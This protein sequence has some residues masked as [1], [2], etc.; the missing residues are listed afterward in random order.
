M[1]KIN[2]IAQKKKGKLPIILGVDLAQINFKAIAIIWALCLL[3]EYFLPSFFSSETVTLNNEIEKL[4]TDF[5][6]LEK[7]LMS[8]EA[9]AAKV[10]M[11]TS[12]LEKLNTRTKQVELVIKDKMNPTRF[13]EKIVR[14]IPDEVWFDELIIKSDKSFSLKAFSSNYKSIGDYLAYLK[15]SPFFQGNIGL[16]ETK[17]EADIIDK[18]KR[19]ERFQI[20]GTIQTFETFGSSL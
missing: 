5:T 3:P 16:M 12:Q 15:S 10:A 20:D 18:A 11:F 14:N 6:A 7:E 13:L 4:N 17:T 1:I 8:N 2:L 9:L 19:V